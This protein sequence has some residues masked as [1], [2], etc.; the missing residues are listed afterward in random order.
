MHVGVASRDTQSDPK[1]LQ[2]STASAT[3]D[4]EKSTCAEQ[5]L[6]KRVVVCTF[7]RPREAN[8]A[9]ESIIAREAM[10]LSFWV[11]IKKPAILGLK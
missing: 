7:E 2:P 10:Q 5:E 4:E 9:C 6:S 11:V 8:K 3:I 1:T